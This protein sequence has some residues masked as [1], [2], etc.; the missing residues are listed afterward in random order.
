MNANSSNPYV[1]SLLSGSTAGL[2]VDLALFPVDTIKTR[3]QSYRNNVQRT[4]GSLRLFAGL[5]AVIVGSAPAAAAFFVVYETVKENFKHLGVHPVYYSMISA[6]IAEV[7]ACVIRVPC[8]VVKQRAQN[9]PSHGVSTVFLQTLRNEGVRGFYRGYISTLSREIPFSFIQYPIWEYLKSVTMEWNRKTIGG[10]STA[11]P[12]VFHLK[13]WQSALCGCLAGT[14][15]GAVTTPLDVAK[16][17]IMLAESNSKLASG[18]V[19]YAMR[20]VF[21]EN[22]IRGLFSGLV[23]RVVLLSFGGAIFLGIY[24]I[25]RRFWILSLQNFR[26]M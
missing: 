4:P 14:I 26:I 15:S 2:C 13:A 5:P 17:R 16:T 9:H 10:D 1:I 7:V 8:E 18:H 12:S 21:Q 23:P 3:L 11:D 20:T 25:S 24:D 6:C 19:L 22:G